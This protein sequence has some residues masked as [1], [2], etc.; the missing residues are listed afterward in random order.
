MAP[1]RIQLLYDKTIGAVVG[2]KANPLWNVTITSQG[3]SKVAEIDLG[4]DV[5]VSNSKERQAEIRNAV[6]KY[7]G[8]KM[9]EG[10]GIRCW[11]GVRGNP[12]INIWLRRKPGKIGV[13]FENTDIL[14]LIQYWC[15]RAGCVSH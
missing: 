12:R 1:D 8:P 13:E 5:A 6:R 15:K 10:E 14:S 3:A 7:L 2:S 4:L 11:L 9:Q